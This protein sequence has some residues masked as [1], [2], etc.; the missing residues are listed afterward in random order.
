M[1]LVSQCEFK[2]MGLPQAK[3][4]LIMSNVVSLTIGAKSWHTF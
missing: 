3:T 4:V 1:N 2:P